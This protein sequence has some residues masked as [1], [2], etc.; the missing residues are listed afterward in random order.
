MRRH[1]CSASSRA[2]DNAGAS[3]MIHKRTLLISL[4]ASAP[5]LRAPRAMAA[6]TYPD[7]PIKLI[8]TVAAGGPMDTIAR[9]IGQQMQAKLGQPVIVEDRPGA[10]S[11]IAAKAVAGS[12]P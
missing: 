5:A 11:T 12:E 3:N 10:G 6:D 8:V 9:F 7:K 1:A 4:A 2:D